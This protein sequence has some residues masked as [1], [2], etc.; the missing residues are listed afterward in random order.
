MPWWFWMLLWVVIILAS[1][2]LYA[3]LGWRLF[4]QGRALVRDASTQMARF[5]QVADELRASTSTFD[6][7]KFQSEA[8]AKSG[9]YVPFI[10]AQTAYVEG[11]QQRREKRRL[12]RIQRK[13]TRNQPQSLRD[14]KHL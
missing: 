10:Q 4:R 12:A 13:L 6:T 9:I 5:S 7:E 1:L 3:W 2:L 11:K 8:L 14:L